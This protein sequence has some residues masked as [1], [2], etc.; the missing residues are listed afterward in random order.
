MLRR[1][2]CT[3]VR[4]SF[5]LSGQSASALACSVYWASAENVHILKATLKPITESPRFSFLRCR[6][7]PL[8]VLPLPK[9]HMSK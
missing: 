1:L 7:W 8:W 3:C 4:L 2:S 9:V 5:L 6:D